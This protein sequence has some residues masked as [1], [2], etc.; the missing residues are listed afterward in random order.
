MLIE[1][2]YGVRKKF[3]GLTMLE[4]LVSLVVVSLGMLGIAALILGALNDATI[5]EKRGK[6]I[7]FAYDLGDRMRFNLP[8][9]AAGDYSCT[10]SYALLSRTPCGT[11]IR[12]FAGSLCTP[13]QL[14]QS[15]LYE[16][17]RHVQQALNGA[18]RVEGNS[19][20]GFMITIAAIDNSMGAAEL[21]MNCPDE[22]RVGQVRCFVNPRVV[23]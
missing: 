7:Q 11:P 3:I 9:A 15:D 10:G 2:R 19:Q 1:S 21:D 4:V 16:W 14:A 22:F 18:A 5:A 8:A 6:A 12:C 20:N 13:A 17:S 23:P